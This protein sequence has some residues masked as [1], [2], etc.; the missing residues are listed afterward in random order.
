MQPHF[1]HGQMIAVLN[2]Y[3]AHFDGDIVDEAMNFTV[4]LMISILQN[5]D[6]KIIKGDFDTGYKRYNLV[7]KEI[8]T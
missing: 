4:E 1:T 3:L 6:K 8:E 2:Y 5:T 7:F